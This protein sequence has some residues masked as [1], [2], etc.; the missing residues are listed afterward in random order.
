MP[1]VLHSGQTPGEFPGLRP[2]GIGAGAKL[3]NRNT[4]TLPPQPVIVSQIRPG[5]PE[6]GW[7]AQR[8]QSEMMG[9]FM[10]QH[11]FTSV[12]QAQKNLIERI[13]S[14]FGPS[15]TRPYRLAAGTLPVNVVSERIRHE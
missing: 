13:G 6:S 10:R 4:M 2:L 7:L 11:L 1:L 12:L 14:E 8:V 3:Q 5:V 9:V 15:R